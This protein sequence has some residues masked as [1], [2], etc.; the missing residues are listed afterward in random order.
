VTSAEEVCY[1]FRFC[2][3]TRHSS[4]SVPKIIVP[5]TELA[6]MVYKKFWA[7]RPKFDC[8]AHFRE[9]AIFEGSPAS[10][11]PCHASACI[12]YKYSYKG[13]G[14]SC[15]GIPIIPLYYMKTNNVGLSHRDD[16]LNRVPIECISC[17]SVKYQS[18]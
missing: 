3:F 15:R 12:E 11:N 14:D 13:P 10:E 1:H 9:V 7:R 2:Q 6:R 18:V 4:P 5:I 17:N 8:L 16:A